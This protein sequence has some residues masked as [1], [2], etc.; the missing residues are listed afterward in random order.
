MSGTERT[1]FVG[2]LADP[3][4]P[5]SGPVYVPYSR[6]SLVLVGANGSGKTRLLS[7]LVSS[8]TPHVFA[9]VPSRLLPYLAAERLRRQAGQAK[10]R[11]SIKELIVEGETVQPVGDEHAWWAGELGHRDLW[12]TL[13]LGANGAAASLSAV[14]RADLTASLI[15]IAVAPSHAE[16]TVERWTVPEAEGNE[17]L[18]A[19]TEATFRSWAGHVLAACGGQ[20]SVYANPLIAG[21]GAG[22]SISLLSLAVAF[23]DVLTRR[24]SDRLRELVGFSLALQCIPEEGFLWKVEM[25]GA[26]IPLEWLS[27]AMSRWASLTAQETLQELDE[28]AAYV[29]AADPA[30]SIEAIL[31]GDRGDLPVPPGQP[32]PFA[33]RSSWVALDEPEVHLFASE[34]RRLGQ[35]LAR[36]GESGRTVIAT[37]SLDLAARF[38]GNADFLMF[39]G[40]GHFTLDQPADG[41]ATLLE[42]LARSGPGILAGTRVLYVEGDWD[43]ELIDR[44]YGDFLARHNILLSRMHGVRGASLAASS[45]WQ[46]LM[47][48]PFGI[49]FDSLGAR[50]VDAQWRSLRQ[51]TA[52]GRR[53]EALR[54]L[55]RAIRQAQGGPQEPIGLLRMFQAVLEGGLEDR[56]YLVMHGLSDIFQVVHPN[57]FGLTAT[58]WTEAG[59]D[60]RGS[61]KQFI[62]SKTS[63]NLADGGACRTVVRKFDQDDRPVES[64]AEKALH[65]AILDFAERARVE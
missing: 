23:A 46:R 39:D 44:L 31:R 50:E 59:Y 8:R 57:V 47:A 22:N 10:V 26:H 5:F 60:G 40:P 52:A 35:V 1:R 61:F 36:H 51:E 25:D 41:V 42:Q 54:R 64:H 16:Q 65:Q 45:V 19:R 53:D 55:R 27:R 2:W 6:R 7:A 21:D 48:T 43:V 30:L 29:A 49:M 14:R 32:G 17:T 20:Y 9:R 28:Y 24:T 13:A 58:T 37:H 56:L 62:G 63:V 12:W 11:L 4:L 38:V 18:S 33:S 15:T 3:G 34:A